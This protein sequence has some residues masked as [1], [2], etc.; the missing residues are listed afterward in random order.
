MHTSVFACIPVYSVQSIPYPCRCILE[1]S[2]S[3]LPCPAL[4]QMQ[5]QTKWSEMKAE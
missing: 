2:W 4:D 3:Q 1:Y 5:L